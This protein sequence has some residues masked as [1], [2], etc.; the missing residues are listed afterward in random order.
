[1]VN[2]E[3]MKKPNREYNELRGER[4]KKDRQLTERKQ[5]GRQCKE[6]Q[7]ADIEG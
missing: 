5:K 7:Q 2:F 6:W 3:R 1:M 4:M